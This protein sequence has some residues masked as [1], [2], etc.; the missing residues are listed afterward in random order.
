MRVKHG[1]MGAKTHCCALFA[2]LR[3]LDTGRV[4]LLWLKV[5]GGRPGPIF[6]RPLL[7]KAK[8]KDTT[9]WDTNQKIGCE[10]LT[11]LAREALA[12]CGMLDVNKV[13]THSGK[14]TGDALG[15]TDAWVT[16]K[17]GWDSASAFVNYKALC[18]RLEMRHPFCK[19]Q[20]WSNVRFHECACPSFLLCARLYHCM[21]LAIIFSKLLSSL[22]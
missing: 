11:T 13:A 5:R 3:R 17:G 18:N 2:H 6:C 15:M 7:R 4:L 9:V 22:R 20:A 19:P 8:G 10:A 14:R 16:D 1:G 21:V 12:D